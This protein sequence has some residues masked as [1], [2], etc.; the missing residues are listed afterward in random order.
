[1]TTPA[2]GGAIRTPRRVA[3]IGLALAL[4]LLVGIGWWTTRPGT[5]RASI[6]EVPESRKVVADFVGSDKCVAC[7]QAQ[8][9]AWKKS[10]HAGAMQH[11]SADTVRGNFDDTSFTFDGVT[12]KFFKRDGK[13]FVRTDGPDGKLADFEVRYTF[14]LE[15]LQQYLVELPGGRLQALAV[16]WDAR[17]AGDGGQRWF[18]QYPDEKLDFRDELHWTQRSQNWNFMCADCHSTNVRKGYD[19]AKDAFATQWSEI[20]VGCESCHGPGSAHL[21]WAKGRPSSDPA[22]GLTVALDERRGAVWQI[23]PASGNAKRTPERRS[24]REI[25][26]CG[27]CHARRAQIAEGWQ[28]GAALMDHYLPSLLSPG[29]YHADGQQRDEVFIWGSFLQSRMHRAGVTCSDC[30]DPHTQKL[31]APGNAVCA[32]CHLA[33][34]YDGKAHHF[35]PEGTRGAECANCHMPATTYMVVDPRRDHSLRVPRPDLS[36]KLGTPNACNDCHRESTAQWSADWVVRWYGAQRRS[37]AHF[38][39]AIDAGRRGGAGAARGL[40]AIVT[41]VAYPPIVRASAVELLARYPGA[42]V[43][44]AVRSALRDADPLV[45]HAALVALQAATAPQLVAAIS[46]LLDDPLRAVRIEAARRVAP[47]AAQL[48]AASRPAF[49]RAIAEYE[50]VQKGNLDRPEAWMNLG[51]LHAMRGDP[52]AADAAFR[53]AL[54]RDVRF[55]P[56]YVNLADLRREQQREADAESV[57]REGLRAAPNAPALHEALGLAL[58]R[59]GKKGEA[60]AEFAAASKSAPTEPRYAYLHALALHDAGRRAEAIR[61]LADA[62]KRTGDRDVLLALA[63]YRSEGGDEAGAREALKGLAAVNPDD[64]AL[65]QMRAPR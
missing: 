21:A 29:L 56:A 44:A 16:T 17:P 19:A 3:W 11:A 9:A 23:D 47:H 10:Q 30:H 38:G 28:A 5:P 40:A 49:D 13:H 55:V 60:L 12:S 26:V 22:K 2:T 59:Q 43:D 15:P 1:M 31:R 32:Q 7:H 46:P 33:S 41:S 25:E 52:A 65:A 61:L 53:G 42:S 18:R 24:G 58:V 8:H 36:V 50:A 34:K 39:E 37:E 27:P 62:A 51:N 20:S 57:L 35:H 64:P 54:K 45:R 63:T 14:G 48:D 4:A 6:S